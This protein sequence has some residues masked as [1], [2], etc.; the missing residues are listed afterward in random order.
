MPENTEYNIPF[1]L[2]PKYNEECNELSFYF[3]SS[4]ISFITLKIII[5]QS[6]KTN[7]QL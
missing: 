7:N 3:P 6:R 5:F 4:L 1:C 2:A